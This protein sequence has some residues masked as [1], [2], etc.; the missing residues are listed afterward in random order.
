MLV[1][2]AATLASLGIAAAAVSLSPELGAAPE[3]TDERSPD[4]GPG[5]RACAVAGARAVIGNTRGQGAFLRVWPSTSSEKLPLPEGT[6]VRV[7]GRARAAEG[8]GW[9]EVEALPLGRRGWVATR[10]LVAPGAAP[11]R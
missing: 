2:S 4:E 5:A 7:T 9:S 3:G 8:L 10:Y 11:R 6:E 1:I